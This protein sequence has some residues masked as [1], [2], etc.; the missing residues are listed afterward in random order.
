MQRNPRDLETL[1][2]LGVRG[3]EKSG[4]GASSSSRGQTRDHPTLPP[5]STPEGGTEDVRSRKNKQWVPPDLRCPTEFCLERSRQKFGLSVT[6]ETVYG[7]P[8][9]T[10]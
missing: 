6:L 4:Q 9:G 3:E 2:P 1:V 10:R 7:P 5:P 8:V